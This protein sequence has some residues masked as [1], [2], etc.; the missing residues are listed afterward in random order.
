MVTEPSSAVIPLRR[1]AIAPFASWTYEDVAREMEEIRPENYDICYDYAVEHDHFRTGEEWVGPGD[2]TAND[3]IEQ[4]FAPEDAVGEVLANVSNAF[5]EPQIGG[6]PLMDLGEGVEIPEQ[7]LRRIA[8]A[9]SLL[10]DWWDRRRL[11]EHVQ[12]RQQTSAWAGFAGLRLWIPAR[13]LLQRGDQVIVQSTEDLA[14]ALSFVHV[15]APLPEYGAMLTDPNTQDQCA[16]YMDEET[17]TAANGEETTY[18]RA[19]LIYLDPLRLDD[20][21]C[22]TII[23]ITYS[24]DEK[25]DRV[26]KLKLGGRLMFAQMNTR[27]LLTEPVIRTQRQLN[28]LTSL[29]TRIAE[30][31]A[32]RERYLKNA[33]PQGTRIPYED[34]DTLAAGSFLERDDEGRLWAVVPE[35]RTLGA[36]TTTELVGLPNYN[37]TGDQRGNVMPDVTIADPVDPAP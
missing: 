5:T 21:D 22:D 3:K 37:D 12:E 33:K 32:F 14:E 29:V 11:Q 23:R 13:H 20:V 26:A 8:E 19:E 6:A 17:I 34:G 16:V 24:D 28:L 15:T 30:T 36:N 18:K 25:P 9:T 4:Q 27:P 1:L 10:S 7:I 31:A 2:A 35:T